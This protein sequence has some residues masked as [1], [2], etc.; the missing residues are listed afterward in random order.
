MIKEGEKAP[1]FC[2]S[3][4]GEDGQERE[5]CLSDLLKNKKQIILYFYPR[6]NTP[7]CTQ[8]AC[9]FRDNLNRLSIK[10]NVTGISHDSI[11][12]H[13][14]FKEKHG[15]NFPLLSDPDH[16]AL[17]LYGAWGEKK[18]YGKTVVSTIRTTV[19]ISHDGK[20][21]KIW[22]NVKVKGHVDKV[23]EEIEG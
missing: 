8:E 19:L 20:I 14:K 3:G 16:K 2:L 21:K 12:S 10:A 18:M 22:N 15:L 1:D 4:I 6:D 5:F 9:D 11:N 17:E 7:G 13:L 23:L